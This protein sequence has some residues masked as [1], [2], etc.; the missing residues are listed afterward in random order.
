MVK[1]DRVPSETI[2]GMLGYWEATVGYAITS[3]KKQNREYCGKLVKEYSKQEIA[4]MI[5]AAALASEDQYAPGVSD[6]IDLYRK[7]DKLKL[8]GKKQGGRHRAASEF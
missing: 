5:Q 6:F 2:D 7:W 8:W 4:A 3:K 1:A